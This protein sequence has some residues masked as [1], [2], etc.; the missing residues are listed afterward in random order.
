MKRDKP[1]SGKA[2]APRPRRTPGKRATL[3]VEKVSD[4]LESLKTQG[5][6]G[7]S[8]EVSLIWER[9]PDVVGM[10]LM[11][12]GRP[13]SVKDETLVIEIDSAVWMHKFSYRKT[14]I[15]NRVNNL[16]RRKLIRDVF[17]VLTQEEKLANPQD[18][19]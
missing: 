8:I 16:V 2:R 19:V 18:D 6:L 15:V 14:D 13:L 3:G 12:Y 17:L 7:R 9:W 4:I 5:V 11:P 10:K 1:G